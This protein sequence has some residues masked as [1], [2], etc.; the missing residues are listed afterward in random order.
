[1]SKV[2][3]DV[4]HPLCPNPL[5]ARAI[6]TLEKDSTSVPFIVIVYSLKTVGGRDALRHKC[7]AQAVTRVEEVSLLKLCGGVVTSAVTREVRADNAYRACLEC[8]DKITLEKLPHHAVR[9]VR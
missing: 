1:M 2:S 8:R 6:V 4:T 7:K 5:S 3:C 9:R